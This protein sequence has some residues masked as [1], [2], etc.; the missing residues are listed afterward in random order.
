MQNMLSYIESMLRSGSM[1]SNGETSY[2]RFKCVPCQ[3]WLLFSSSSSL[4]RCSGISNTF[5]HTE[6]AIMFTCIQ[7]PF[8]CISDIHIYS[9]IYRLDW[10]KPQ[11]T[12]CA[13][14]CTITH[15]LLVVYCPPPSLPP[16]PETIQLLIANDYCICIIDHIQYFLRVCA[17]VQRRDPN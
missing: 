2:A 4:A 13:M 16:I 7:P 17:Q 11:N 8:G 1:R 10:T 14:L 5:Q 15:E 3:C 12:L 9:C 6:D